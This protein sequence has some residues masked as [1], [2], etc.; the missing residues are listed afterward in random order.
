MYQKYLLGLSCKILSLVCFCALSLLLEIAH[1]PFNS[2]EQFGILC[3]VGTFLM[4]PMVLIHF[5]IQLKTIQ[6]KLYFLRALLSI[7]AMVSWME[8]VKNIGS[9]EAVL[10]SY[11]IPIFTIVLASL[12]K[13]EKLHHTCLISGIACFM[14]VAVALKPKIE[15]SVYGVSMAFLSVI[16]WSSYEIICKKQT[17]HEH[18]F[19]QVF[20]TFALA[21]LLLLPFS[22]GQLAGLNPTDWLLISC[23]AL[24]RI[25]TIILLFLALKWATLNWVA[26]VSYLKFPILAAIGFIC[27]ERQPSL[28][29]WMIAFGLMGINL[30]MMVVRRYTLLK[31]VHLTT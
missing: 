17:H 25:A 7:V 13:E 3:L 31:T 24:L 18:F 16:S 4:L 5:R 19:I 22:L 6:L 10:M 27:L 29:H 14:M 28:S 9:S 30:A 20:C 23:M 21:A 8:A 26:C 12:S 1:F 2:I 15:F 11:L